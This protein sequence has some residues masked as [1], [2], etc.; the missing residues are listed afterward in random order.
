M[1][2]YSVG[3]AEKMLAEI[4]EIAKLALPASAAAAI[5]TARAAAAAARG[6]SSRLLGC[7]RQP[8]GGAIEVKNG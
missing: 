8:S 3:G 6:D 5:S 7:L 4:R 2:S 1:I